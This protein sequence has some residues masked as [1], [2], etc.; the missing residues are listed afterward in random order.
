MAKLQPKIKCTVEQNKQRAR[1][2]FA[3]TWLCEIRMNE[4]QVDEDDSV[5][6]YFVHEEA[7]KQFKSAVLTAYTGAK[8][9]DVALNRLYGTK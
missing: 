9:T 2:G 5:L 1:D 6:V 4:I 3:D 8:D 7:A